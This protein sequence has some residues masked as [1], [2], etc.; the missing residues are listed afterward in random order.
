MKSELPR[1]ESRSGTPKSA[2]PEPPVTIF[3]AE[4]SESFQS[5]PGFAAPQ[6]VFRLLYQDQEAPMYNPIPPPRPSLLL[7]SSIPPSPMPVLAA[8]RI[9]LQFSHLHERARVFELRTRPCD[10]SCEKHPQDASQ[11]PG[12]PPQPI[13]KAQLKTS[14][15]TTP[16]VPLST[17]FFARRDELW[18]R[19]LGVPPGSGGLSIRLPPVDAP[20]TTAEN[21]QHRLRLCRY[22][23]QDGILR[24]VGNRPPSPNRAP[25]SP[26][27]LVFQSTRSY[28]VLERTR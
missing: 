21:R 7:L 28:Y 20:A 4:F 13:E 22:V 9:A 19:F 27:P 26:P 24:A 17:T 15:L 5:L 8:S 11:N 23:G 6:P 12:P 25:P 14:C 16:H 18:G 2:P 3:F 1:Q 10:A